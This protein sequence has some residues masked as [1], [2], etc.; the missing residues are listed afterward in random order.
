[1]LIVIE[2]LKK[3]KKRK[4][5]KKKYIYSSVHYSVM[6]RHLTNKPVKSTTNNTLQN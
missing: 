4:R 2:N 3:R 5:K 6:F 1:M